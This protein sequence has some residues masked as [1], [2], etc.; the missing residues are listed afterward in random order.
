[1]LL[2]KVGVDVTDPKFWELGLRLLGDMVGEAE[3]LAA[4]L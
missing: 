2:A 4:K 3:A 1:M